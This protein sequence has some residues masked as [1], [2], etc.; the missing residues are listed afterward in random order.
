MT[1]AVLLLALLPLGASVPDDF[2]CAWRH[3]AQ[4]YAHSIQPG[5]SVP[6]AAA[7][8]ESLN[9]SFF[10]PGFDPSNS[11][12]TGGCFAKLRL[13]KG[14]TA[15]HGAMQ[16]AGPSTHTSVLSAAAQKSFYVAAA[17]ARSCSDGGGSGG[18]TATS[19]F[20]SVTRGVAACRTAATD[21]G[22]RQ[23]ALL[24][25]AGT[26]RLNETLLLGPADSGLAIVGAPA[27]QPVN[28]AGAGGAVLSGAVPITPSW[29]QVK[30]GIRDLPLHRCRKLAVQFC[31]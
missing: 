30:G 23:C 18:G 14:R 8:E 6:N 22:A 29:K 19:P 1:V 26:H 27:L 10:G 3:A 24:L 9:S 7:L 25:G 31:S 15:A 11:R 21:G 13:G 2:E 5:M 20:C 17:G 16:P 12:P 28:S 4:D